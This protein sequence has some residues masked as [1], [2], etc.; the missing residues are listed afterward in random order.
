MQP[1][2][3]A[4]QQHTAQDEASERGQQ[5]GQIVGWDAQSD[6]PWKNLGIPSWR[7]HKN[8]TPERLNFWLERS[9]SRAAWLLGCALVLFALASGALLLRHLSRAHRN[10]MR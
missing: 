10:Q 9:S 8:P 6:Y 3:D 2:E 7:P 1:S 4:R 5:S